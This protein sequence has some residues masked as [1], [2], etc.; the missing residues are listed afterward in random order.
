MKI[1]IRSL[2]GQITDSDISALT[3]SAQEKSRRMVKTYFVLGGIFV[4]SLPIPV[5]HFIAPPLCIILGIGFSIK[6]LGSTQIKI[7][8]TGVCPDCRKEFPV[9][10]LTKTLPIKTF[11]PNCRNQIYIED[12]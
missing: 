11:C 5:V 9:S 7:I 10:E 6:N 1:Q 2:S 4:I 8:G 3:E 12:N